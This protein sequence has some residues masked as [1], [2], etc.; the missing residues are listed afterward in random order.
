LFIEEE[1]N[2]ASVAFIV[3]IVIILILGVLI[4]VFVMR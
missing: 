1:T 4:I 2:G 3:P